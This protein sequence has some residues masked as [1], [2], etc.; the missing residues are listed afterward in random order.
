MELEDI[1]VLAD[2]MAL[3][4]GRI[5]I[6]SKGSSGGHK[7]LG[8]IIEKFGGDEFVRLRVGIGASGVQAGE[9]YVLGRPS[10]EDRKL[11]AAALSWALG[12]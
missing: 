2:D 5:R 1:I 6:R 3:D 12:L 9:S 7:G 4:A 8:D 10:A 11:I